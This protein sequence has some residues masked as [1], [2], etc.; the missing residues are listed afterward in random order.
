MA[1]LGATYRGRYFN[2]PMRFGIKEDQRF[3]QK[4]KGWN[5]RIGFEMPHFKLSEYKNQFIANYEGDELNPRKNSTLTVNY[6]VNRKFHMGTSDS[7]KLMLNHQRRD[8]YISASGEIESREE[9]SQ[10]AENT[11]TYQ[12]GRGLNFTFHGRIF[13][14][15]LKISTLGS[16]QM[17]LKRE[18]N[19]FNSRGV[20]R[21]NLQ[22][23]KFRGELFFSYSSEEQKYQLFDSTRPSPFSGSLS[24]APDN[25][26]LYTTLSVKTGWR[27]LS[28]DSLIFYSGI[29]RYRYD[30]PDPENFDDRDELRFNMEI[31][32]VHKFSPALSLH[33]LV[34]LNLFHFVYIYGERSA[35]NNW[36]RILRFNPYLIYRPSSKL[37]F[38][39][40]AEVLANYVDYDYESMFPGIKSF[41]YRKFQL[42]ES[43]YVQLTPRSSFYILYR[44]EL[45]EN[46]KFLWDQWVEQ[47]LV[48]RESHT[49]TLSFNYQP[50]TCITLSPGF[51]YYSRRGYR[52][53]STLLNEQQKDLNLHFRNYGPIIKII[54]KGN[55]LN[56]TFI[57]STI[58]TKTLNIE[59][60]TIARINLRLSW[61]L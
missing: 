24:A 43:C 53:S 23:P 46:G 16:S 58:A 61:A 51:S 42:E 59:K 35:D 31:V 38:Y 10:G 28:S 36:T 29:Q 26:S 57:G 47:K 27:F 54:Y 20:I 13:S 7:L 11:L 5:Y 32:E 14:R 44:L 39:Q 8:Y 21:L 15:S 17:D 1:A 9:K 18:R 6:F 48:D 30:T 3:G 37:R 40:S 33:L 34:G 55:R 49:L 12:I 41:L 2:I 22:R 60:K 4:D 45:D 56:C 50:W 25:Q 19:D 52:Y